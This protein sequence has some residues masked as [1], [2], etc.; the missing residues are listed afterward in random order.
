MFLDFYQL[1]EQPFG[2]TPNPAYL[3]RSQTHFAAL[4]ALSSGVRNDRGF[5]AL[6]AEP[7]MGKTTL[8][9]QLVED[10]RDSARAVYFSQTQCSSREVLQFIFSE[11]NFGLENP[12]LVALHKRRNGSFFAGLFSD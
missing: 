1:R 12:G 2:V 5:L 6:I 11:M 3:Y 9:C 10:F 4:D 8:L 7:G